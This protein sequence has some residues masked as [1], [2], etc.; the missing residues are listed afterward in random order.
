MTGYGAEK[1][2]EIS[3][4]AFRLRPA[5]QLLLE[6]DKPVHL[7]SRARDI[8]V[9]LLER[10]GQILSKQEL[11]DRVWP[12]TFVEEG[13]LKVHVAALRRALGDGQA[14]KRFIANIPGRGY[15][16]VA[17]VDHGSAP[18]GATPPAERVEARQDLPMPLTRMVGRSD[19]VAALSAQV[20]RQRFVTIV[21]AGGI[22]KTTV[23]VAVA[24][25]LAG[26]FKDGVRFVDLAPLSDPLLAPGALATVL[27]VGLG[28]EKPLSNVIAFLREK[29]I[30]IVLDNCE[31]LIEAAARMAEDILKGAPWIHILATSR[32]A[33]RSEGERVH[34]LA[35][36]AFPQGGTELTAAEALAFPAVQLFV[37][38]A[39]ACLDAFELGDAEAPLVAEICRRLDGIALA[40]E[41][42]A[43][44]VDTFG[45]AGLAARLD[46]RF[47]L[48]LRGRRTALP[49]HQ[50]LLTTLDW[51]Y[52]LLPELQQ[53]VLRRLAVFAGMFTMESASA[54]LADGDTPASEIVDAIADLIAKSLVTA[55]VDAAVALYRLLDTT[56]AYALVKLDECGERDRFARRHAEHYRALLEQAY[57]E[58]E[59]EP[60]ADWLQRYRH[61]IDN[62]RAALDWAFSPAG[63]VEAG[64][65]LTVVA[66]PLWFHLSLT[67]EC[68]E[69]VDR[70]L[71]APA[72]TRSL[73]Q[74]MRLH[75]TR[76]WSLMQTKGLGPD[77]LAAWRRVLETSE[78]L[79][80]RDYQLRALWGLWSGLLNKGGFREALALGRRFSELAGN[81]GDK[82]GILVGDRMVGYILHLLGEQ[83][84]ARHTIERMLGRYEVPVIGAQMIRFVFDQRAMA[85]CFLARILWLQGR[86]THAV[87]MVRSIVDGAASGNDT[88]TL[89]QVLVHAACPVALFVGDRPLVEHYVSMLIDNAAQG[90][91]FWQGW[92]RCFRGVLRIKSGELDR[93]LAELE[94]ALAELREIQYGVY[95]IVFQSEYAA[96]LGLAGNIGEGLAAIDEALARSEQNDERWYFAEILRI[97]GEL[98]LSYGAPD[99]PRE[100]ELYYHRSL[101]WARRQQTIAWELRTA[102]SLARLWK[103]QNRAGEALALLAPIHD[104]FGEGQDTHDLV[105]AQE[106][107]QEL[108]AG[109]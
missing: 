21:G 89:C 27:G 32:E 69:R 49:R 85:R 48:L 3:F 81:V 107:L 13:N 87:Q 73:D 1:P 45:I 94:A 65:A 66:I 31:H 16:F 72:A 25:T 79:Q 76:A 11:L 33:L 28:S 56:R 80:N 18:G 37:E 93:G 71:A 53:V 6:D 44:R 39:A 41:I 8:L 64:V 19:T 23:A 38:R 54:V 5:Q 58:W 24:D 95:Y 92:G 20:T 7:G 63:D 97:K 51:S 74:E 100:A 102:T 57:G 29:A 59:R 15:S 104:R 34:R 46:E 106:L 103:D 96:A 52:A 47:S 50:T 82:L 70:A 78:Q 91:A 101:E 30:L 62:V 26:S 105:V 68:E 90:L 77:T 40:I 43:G 4:G 36:L 83:A 61:N 108:R 98:I 12:D 22:G 99:G 84:E 9:A 86:P 35:P 42:V 2:S 75:A 88:L 60:A 10:P 14:G 55:S 109:S 67:S 17:P